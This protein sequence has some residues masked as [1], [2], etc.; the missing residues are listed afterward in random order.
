M[1][2]AVTYYRMSAAERE[3]VMR[4]QDTWRRFER[5]LMKAYHDAFQS[6]IA[7]MD[8]DGG[9][10][11]E[12]FARL[13]LLMKERSDPRQFNLEKDWHTTAYLLTGQSEI[14]DDHRSGETLHNVIYGGLDTGMTTGYG[15]V[16]YFDSTLVTESAEALAGADR[17]AIAR[18]FDPAQM[19]QLEIY[20]APD[21]RER[22][23]ILKVIENLADFFKTAAAAKDDVIKFA[24]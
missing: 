17:Q 12:Q 18:R 1:S 11:A 19:A 4:D 2:I 5:R 8:K 20:A 15:A 23:G 16:R 3:S 24:S 22:E 6:A 14:G 10:R 13:A 7:D 21:E 9:T